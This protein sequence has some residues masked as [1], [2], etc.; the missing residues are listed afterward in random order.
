[1]R[2]RFSMSSPSRLRRCGVK[3][4]ARCCRTASKPLSWSARHGGRRHGSNECERPQPRHRRISL[5]CNGPQVLAGDA[6]GIPT[7]VEIAP[8]FVAVSRA[9]CVVH[10]RAAPR[11]LR[12]RR[13]NGGGRCRCGHRGAGGCAGRRRR[14]GR[15]RRCHR[16]MSS[17]RRRRG[18][19]GSPGP[20][21]CPQCGIGRRRAD[22][23][24][25]SPR[26]RWPAGGVLAAVAAS[27]ALLCVGL[28]VRSDVNGPGR[29]KCR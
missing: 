14:C 27:V 6:P 26:R 21:A 8:E 11:G 15:A 18:D 29:P 12:R 9:G 17:G 10:G 19:D 25:E 5:C 4:S 7:V 24:L 1:M 16:R 28:A 3:C 20:G 23:E 2:S 22:T 13:Q